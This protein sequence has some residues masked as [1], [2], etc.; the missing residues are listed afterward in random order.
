MDLASFR[1]LLTA[2]GQTAL[3]EALALQPKEAD[4][5]T[6][7]GKMQKHYPVELARAALETA[8]LRLSADE[9][10]PNAAN[11]YFTREAL[12]QA[13]SSLVASYRAE[14]YC[15]CSLL[16]DLGCSI[17]ADTLALAG[18]APTLGID[19]DPLRLAI[20]Q[21]NAAVVQPEQP[22]TFLQADL[23]KPLPFSPLEKMGLFFDPARRTGTRRAFSVQQYQPPLERISAWLESFPA[24]G[25][26]ISPGVNLAELSPYPAE[27]EFISVQGSLKEAVLWF[28]PLKNVRRRAT[29]LPGPHVMDD[30]GPPEQ[31]VDFSLP[32]AEPQEFIF[33]P[34]PAVIRAGLVQDLG[35]Q[36]AAAQLDPDIAYLTAA[37]CTLTPFGRWWKVDAWF[38]FQL[39]RLREALRQRHVGQ[40]TIKKRGSPLTPEQLIPQLRLAGS[41]RRVVFLTHLHGRPIV[42]LAYDELSP[43]SPAR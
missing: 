22:V 21:V 10:F 13:T 24:L 28:G 37:H 36:I 12:E 43:P 1:A 20:A 8:I 39:K 25:V 42:I 30:L 41:E 27:I 34:D 29:L 17:G 18:I 38:P 16:V 33:E 19:L 23:T 26:K 14:R 35:R 5:L 6:L 31:G 9:K 32:L 40:V 2:Q 15:G 11:L 4:F 3:Q 7:L